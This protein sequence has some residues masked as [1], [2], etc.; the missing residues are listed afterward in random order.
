MTDETLFP[1]PETVE[2]TVTIRALTINKRKVTDAIYRQ[3][4]A[5]ALLNADGTLNGTPWGRVE[6]HDQ[7]CAGWEHMHVLWERASVLYRGMVT[8]THANVKGLAVWLEGDLFLPVGLYAL[9]DWL[10]A[11]DAPY[12]FSESVVYGTAEPDFYIRTAHGFRFECTAPRDL[13]RRAR[14]LKSARD[15]SYGPASSFTESGVWPDGMAA[16]AGEAHLRADV[17]AQIQSAGVSRAQADALLAE[18]TAAEVARRERV[19]AAL[20]DL[21]TLPQL[22]IGA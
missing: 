20:A 11:H 1:L 6:R 16:P 2:R 5:A 12:P 22:F 7:T 13:Y 4:P 19:R 3:F 9:Q 14:E 10:N 15:T 18:F 21:A 8:D 17:A